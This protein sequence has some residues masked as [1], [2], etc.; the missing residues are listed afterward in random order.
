MSVVDSAEVG[1]K[2]ADPQR[3]VVENSGGWHRGW[4]PRLTS[5]ETL[6]SVVVGRRGVAGLLLQSG[7]CVRKGSV[8]QRIFEAIV[9]SVEVGRK[10]AAVRLACRSVRDGGGLTKGWELRRRGQASGGSVAV[11]SGI[12]EVLLQSR[13][14]S[15]RWLRKHPAHRSG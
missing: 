2:T 14:G 3:P 10:R 1:R 9:D 6:G 4:V 5:Q 12:A 7:G 8:L 15:G 13:D 11:G